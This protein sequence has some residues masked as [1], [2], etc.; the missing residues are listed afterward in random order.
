[1]EAEGQRG[2]AGDAPKRGRI[3]RAGLRMDWWGPTRQHF[4]SGAKA[5]A[6]LYAGCCCPRSSLGGSPP[7][8]AP[9][10][11][12]TRASSSPRGPSTRLE[13]EVGN[14]TQR[15]GRFTRE[16]RDALAS[17][18]LRDF[19]AKKYDEGLLHAVDYFA[20]TVHERRTGGAAPPR[21]GRGAP[22]DEE[23]EGGMGI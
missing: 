13:V 5:C 18:L 9:A 16:D 21:A 20:S 2:R 22:P 1:G 3:T 10:S 7:R 17:R 12:R 15:E 14:Q 4:L 6:I 8:R 19:E 23:K 11:S